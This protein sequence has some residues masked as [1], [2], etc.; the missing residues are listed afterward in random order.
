M[1]K[2]AIWVGIGGGIGS[3]LR[4]LS[5]VLVAKLF[6]GHFPL[7]TFLVNI[8]GCLIAGL[9]IGFFDKQSVTNQEMRYLL[10]TGFCGGYTTFS[11]FA[12]ENVSLFQA[13]NSFVAFLYIATSI[14][15]GLL[16]VWL[17]LFL[18]KL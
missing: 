17:G 16:A 15:T 3:M 13:G 8:L 7:A 1:I 9:L 5:S 6:S 14:I 11:A 4:Y 18:T 12:A 2:I 10:I